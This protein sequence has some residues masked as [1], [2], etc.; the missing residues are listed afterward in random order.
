M[1]NLSVPITTQ[2]AKFGVHV[3]GAGVRRGCGHR[4][5]VTAPPPRDMSLVTQFKSGAPLRSA[6]MIRDVEANPALAAAVDPETKNT[7]LHFACCNGAPLPL[8]QALLKADG[9]AAQKADGDGNLAIVGAVANG[10]SAEVVLALLKA[11]PSS[12]QVR[13][14]KHTLLHSAACNGQSV[15]TIA[16]LVAAWPGAAAERDEEGNTPLHFAAACQA[17]TAVVKALLA[18]CPE[19]ASWRG[20]MQRFPLSLCLLCEA[21][22]GSV[23]AIRDAYP[24]AQRATELVGD[25]QNHGFGLASKFPL[26]R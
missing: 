6:A 15:E 26:A 10:C 20:H 11:N 21:P 24:Q 16:A 1:G 2:N 8:V 9:S 3:S 5:R 19:A 14:G 18:A 13:K 22:P 23:E 17:P 25:Y 4:A 12:A 7:P